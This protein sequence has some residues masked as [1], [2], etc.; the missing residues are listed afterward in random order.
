MQ[1]GAHQPA[2]GPAPVLGLGQRPVGTRGPDFEHVGLLPHDLGALRAVEHVGDHP[3]EVGDRV[4]RHAVVAVHDDLDT[5]PPGHLRDADRLQVVAGGGDGRLQQR[6]QPVR[7]GSGSG[8][9]HRSPCAV[10]VRCVVLVRQLRS[11]HS[12]RS[13]PGRAPVGAA[14]RNRYTLPVTW[15]PVVLTRRMM[16]DCDGCGACRRLW[17]PLRQIRESPANSPRQT[18]SGRAARSG[19][20][21]RA[22]RRGGSAEAVRRRLGAA[23]RVRRQRAHREAHGD[24]RRAR[25][26]TPPP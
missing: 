11:Q 24:P 2:L 17:F 13:A 9:A 19:P 4:E 10:V 23:L 6:L 15:V 18:G 14:R 26:R 7:R 1:D 3:G 21:P 25:R 5:A 16:L 20:R 22:R 12:I 8:G